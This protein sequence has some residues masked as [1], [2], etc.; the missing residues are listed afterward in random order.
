MK[1]QGDHVIFTA[2]RTCTLQGCRFNEGDQVEVTLRRDFDPDREMGSGKGPW[3]WAGFS[4]RFV[5]SLGAVE[6]Q[7]GGRLIRRERKQKMS[8]QV[9]VENIQVQGRKISARVTATGEY[10]GITKVYQCETN[11]EGEGLWIN[12]AQSEGTCQF[13]LT[14]NH[15]E[16]RRALENRFSLVPIL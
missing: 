14:T 16:I 3:G 1:Y 5:G 12:G 11:S 8:N 13:S 15:N 6:V 9:S 10:T 4:S 2:T 7:S